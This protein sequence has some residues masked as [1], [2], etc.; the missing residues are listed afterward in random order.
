M[1]KVT[2]PALIA[3]LN[4][5]G[6]PPPIAA[7][8]NREL[9]NRGQNA[10]AYRESFAEADTYDQFMAGVGR[11]PMEAWYG[12]KELFGLDDAEHIEDGNWNTHFERLEKE[13]EEG[14]SEELTR[15]ATGRGDDEEEVEV[16]DDV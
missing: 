3:K 13:E 7:D 11:G 12:G 1:R 14:R 8:I 16:D 5:G 4:A 15:Q 10:D 9:I 6:N 2:D